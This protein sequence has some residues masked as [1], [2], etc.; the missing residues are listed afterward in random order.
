[1]MATAEC[2]GV[3]LVRMLGE[4]GYVVTRNLSP[5]NSRKLPKGAISSRFQR[6]VQGSV[7]SAA[8]SAHQ[9]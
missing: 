1:M 5:C 6:G 8:E 7:F 2:V 4:L 9:A 3:L